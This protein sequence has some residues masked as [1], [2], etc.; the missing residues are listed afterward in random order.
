MSENGRLRFR[1]ESMTASRPTDRF[2]WQSSANGIAGLFL[3]LFLVGCGQPA[4]TG[5]PQSA[6][7]LA[8]PE[9]QEVQQSTMPQPQG[10]RFPYV[11][12]EV[13]VRFKPEADTETITRVLEELKLEKV[14]KYQSPNHYLVKITDGATVDTIIKNLYG[15]EAV[16]YAEPNYGVKATH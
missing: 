14:H 5:N 10:K 3:F 12:D 8:Q 4:D 1:G 13:L 15:F 7:T 11:P 6:P 16:E 2:H 9:V